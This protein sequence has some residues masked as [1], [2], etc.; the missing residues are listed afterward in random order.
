MLHTA[1]DDAVVFITHADAPCTFTL[2]SS[3]SAQP[4]TATDAVAL[5]PSFAPE[6]DQML[7]SELNSKERGGPAESVKRLRGGSR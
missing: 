2:M 3:R 7:A 1:I 6:L 5:F 4:A